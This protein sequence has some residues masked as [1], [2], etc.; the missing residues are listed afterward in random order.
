MSTEQAY[1]Q[2]NRSSLCWDRVVGQG[3]KG[4]REKSRKV[5]KIIALALEARKSLDFTMTASESPK[6]LKQLSNPTGVIL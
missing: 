5:N 4:V 2:E 1:A 6:I 3:K